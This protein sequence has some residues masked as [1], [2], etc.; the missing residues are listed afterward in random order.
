MQVSHLD[1]DNR[2][3]LRLLGQVHHKNFQPP[4]LDSISETR[5]SF[6]SRALASMSASCGRA[7]SIHAG[8]ALHPEGAVCQF[9]SWPPGSAVAGTNGASLVAVVQACRLARYQQIPLRA[10][11][12]APC[13]AAFSVP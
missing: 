12:G 7:I 5:W 9:A 10:V 8:Q 6:L 4:T 3:E 2:G 1:Q 13:G 11:R